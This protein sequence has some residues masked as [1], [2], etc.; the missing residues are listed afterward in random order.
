VFGR[1][2]QETNELENNFFKS[3]KLFITVRP[4]T[5]LFLFEN[6]KAKDRLKI[7]EC[8]LKG[9]SMATGHEAVDWLHVA[10]DT[11]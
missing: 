7:S 9:N 3:D 5:K 6:V 8:L 2:A 11:D 1:G 4:Q 10:K